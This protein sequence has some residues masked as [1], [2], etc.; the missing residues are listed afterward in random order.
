MS[1]FF[2]SALSNWQWAL[3][4]IVPP[5]IV[6][7]YFLKLKRQPGIAESEVLPP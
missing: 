1:E 5:A 2:S 6:L 4:A 3:L 7:L